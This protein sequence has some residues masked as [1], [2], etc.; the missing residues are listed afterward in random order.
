MADIDGR[1]VMESATTTGTVW[2]E[3]DCDG[4]AAQRSETLG[5]VLLQD[6]VQ[7]RADFTKRLWPVKPLYMS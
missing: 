5:E 4:V 2:T 6:H 3:S 7:K 1:L